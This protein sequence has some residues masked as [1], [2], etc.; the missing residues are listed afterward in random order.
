MTQPLTKKEIEDF[1][2]AVAIASGDEG[3]REIADALTPEILENLSH[4]RNCLDLI[5]EGW[6]GD[7]LAIRGYT[8]QMMGHLSTARELCEAYTS[9]ALGAVEAAS[10]EVGESEPAPLEALPAV[11]IV[12]IHRD[13]LEAVAGF[14]DQFLPAI[15][16]RG[17][18]P[19]EQLWEQLR[20][21]EVQ[22]HIVWDTAKETA[23]AL[24]GTCVVIRGERRIG[25]IVWC[26]GKDRHDWWFH[27]L[28]QLETHL[29]EH[30]GCEGFKVVCRPGWKK[31][32]Q[33]LGYR[34][35]HIVME[36]DA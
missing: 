27:L 2:R 6:G 19:V 12:T 1:N 5:I 23:V 35:T 20:S 10:S 32:C 11:A 15:S 22:A 8:S 7:G 16:K 28:T 9:L 30:L 21:G 25:E 33:E 4:A 36:R 17:R 13:N 24:A 29:R 18:I 31:H 34:L 3:L 14:I 26:T